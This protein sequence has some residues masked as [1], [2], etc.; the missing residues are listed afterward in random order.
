MFNLF[1]KSKPV[2]IKTFKKFIPEW[3][4]K[5]NT[6][7]FM[8]WATHPDTVLHRFK[9][10]NSFSITHKKH[11]E[12]FMFL[13]NQLEGKEDTVVYKHENEIFNLPE[14][15]QSSLREDPKVLTKKLT[16]LYIK[17]L[18]KI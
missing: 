14:N 6:F 3:Y 1:K 10:R 5:G 4:V 18:S 15:I 7:E 13:I 16:D 9:E 17:E 11:K 8:Y 12:S 2:D